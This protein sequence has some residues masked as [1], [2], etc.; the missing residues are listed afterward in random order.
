MNTPVP[1]CTTCNHP[2]PNCACRTVVS[3]PIVSAPPL[4]PPT[5]FRIRYGVVYCEVC[6]LDARYCRGHT[7]PPPTQGDGDAS[8]LNK[9]IRALKGAP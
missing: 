2:L 4:P 5:R 8:D 9:R 7:P 1:H 3:V 6:D